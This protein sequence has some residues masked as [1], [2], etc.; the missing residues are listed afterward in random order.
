M[1]M[2]TLSRLCC[3]EDTCI[4]KELNSLLDP[5]APIVDRIHVAACAIATTCGKLTIDEQHSCASRIF[6]VPPE[7]ALADAFAIAYQTERDY[8][9]G[10]RDIK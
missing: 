1:G 8:V 6:D 3:D 7:C 9:V 10:K 4:R 5:D 2:E